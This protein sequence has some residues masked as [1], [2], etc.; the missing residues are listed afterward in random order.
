MV[1]KNY[2]GTSGG[3]GNRSRNSRPPKRGNKPGSHTLSRAIASKIGVK[4]GGKPIGTYA[5]VD[6]PTDPETYYHHTG[7]LELHPNGYGFLRDPTNDYTR[8]LS[9]PFVPGNMIE[10][11]GLREGVLMTG[12]IQ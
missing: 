7:A 12:L 8:I 5:I 9:D 1:N 6:D 4:K 10:K 2:G 3:N 11:F